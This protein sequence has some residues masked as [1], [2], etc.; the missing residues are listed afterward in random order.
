FFDR[1][2]RLVVGNDGGMWRLEN[3]TAPGSAAAANWTNL[4]NNGSLTSF[5]QITTF[6]GLDVDPFNPFFAVGGAQDT[7]TSIYNDSPTWTNVDGGDGGIVR[8]NNKNQQI[9]FHVENGVLRR[10]TS[11]G[12]AGS[13]NDV[14]NN[15][16]NGLYFPFILDR[17]NPSRVILG[18][19]TDWWE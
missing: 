5:L 11:G 3:T 12:V 6:N 9:M 17:V 4:N 14:Y 13:W 18:D 1:N 19:G 10:S 16:N 8:I 15:V 2:G 7:G